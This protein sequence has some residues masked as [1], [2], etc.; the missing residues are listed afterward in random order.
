MDNVKICSAD[1]CLCSV[2]ELR[3]IYKICGITAQFL[4]K[5]YRSVV[6]NLDVSPN[7]LS[8]RSD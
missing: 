4:P 7:C 2:E 8:G 1:R 3:K 6:R 5:L